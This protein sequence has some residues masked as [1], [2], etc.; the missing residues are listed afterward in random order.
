M[1]HQLLKTTIQRPQS[2]DCRSFINKSPC[3]IMTVNPAYVCKNGYRP[4]KQ[5]V[6]Y[7]EFALITGA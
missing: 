6:P 3:C 2:N 5:D 4:Y 7:M 1:T